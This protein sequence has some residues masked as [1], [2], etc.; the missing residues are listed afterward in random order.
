MKGTLFSSDFAVDGSDNL[1]LLEINTDT[2]IASA[3]FQHFDFSPL[4]TTWTDNSIS[5]LHIIYKD[6]Q[7]EFVEFFSSSVADNYSGT[8]GIDLHIEEGNT[9]YP[10]TIADAADKFILRL[11]YDEA[12]ILDST[13]AKN[14]L[15]LLDLFYDNANTISLIEWP[16]I[17]DEKLENLIELLFEYEKDHQNRSVQIKGLIL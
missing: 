2:G 10:Y 15:N 12:A 4:Y 9:I 13:Y 5:E 14:N 11:A 6:H 3:S 8:I 7:K 1:R 16:Q 17:I